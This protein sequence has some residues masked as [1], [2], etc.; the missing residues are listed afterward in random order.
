MRDRYSRLYV[1]LIWATWDRLPLIDE[2]IRAPVYRAI[3]E[4]ARRAG[5]EAMAV[6]GIAD[7]VHVLVQMSTA[8]S[9][10][11]VVK[12]M[13]GGSSHLAPRVLRPGAFFKWQGSYGAFSISRTHVPAVSA[14]IHNQERHH[15][16]NRLSRALE[17]VGSR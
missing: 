3:A 14:Y 15:A 17:R 10:G 16:E 9:V 4:Q 7:H 5:C 1:H 12:S 11:D 2:E 13:K 8:V 6:G